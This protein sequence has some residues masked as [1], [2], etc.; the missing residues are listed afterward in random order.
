[1]A[2]AFDAADI[3]VFSLMPSCRARLSA[4]PPATLKGSPYIRR[5]GRPTSGDRVALHQAI[6]SPYIR[7]SG[8]P[9]SGDRV[10]LRQA[11]VNGSPCTSRSPDA[12]ALR[13]KRTLV[14]AAAAARLERRAHLVRETS[15]AISPLDDPVD[16]GAPR[17]LADARRAAR[18]HAPHEILARPRRERAALHRREP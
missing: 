11:T 14:D 15:R 16:R 17:A 9:T 6:G 1:M 18:R 4:S 12:R 7:R 13:A 5:P 3:R 8:R 10:A 2:G